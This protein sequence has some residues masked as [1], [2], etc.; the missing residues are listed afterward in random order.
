MVRGISDSCWESSGSHK[1]EHQPSIGYALKGKIGV[2]NAHGAFKL[3]FASER[4]D[5]I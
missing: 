2:S 3:L 5:V 4:L 1:K